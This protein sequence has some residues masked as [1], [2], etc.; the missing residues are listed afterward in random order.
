MRKIGLIIILFLL[1]S[2]S[3]AQEPTGRI[4]FEKHRDKHRVTNVMDHVVMLLID[5]NGNRK[6]RSLKRYNKKFQDSFMRSLIVF[7]EPSDLKG[8]ALLTRQLAEDEYKQWLYL[9]D[10]KVLQRIA[11]RSKRSSFM[12]S[13]FT[14]EDLQPD[15]MNNYNFSSPETETID[16]Q[17]CF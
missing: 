17:D 4:I 13:D 12:G 3:W 14:Y 15:S 6:V 9:P 1:S 10:Q 8:T 7:L 11:S 2:L 5:K 16:N